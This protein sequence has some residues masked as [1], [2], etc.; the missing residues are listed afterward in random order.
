MGRKTNQRKSINEQFELLQEDMDRLM[1]AQSQLYSNIEEKTDKLSKQ[2]YQATQ[3]FE[4]LTKE[5]MR[6]I[7]WIDNQKK[8]I[9]ELMKQLETTFKEREKKTVLVKKW[10]DFALYGVLVVVLFQ[11]L[12]TSLWDTLGFSKLYSLVHAYKYGGLIVTVIYIALTIAGL[13]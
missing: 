10:L 1:Q 11:A 6:E 12:S 2:T 7:E 3:M 5:R 9:V 8:V 13:V 4:D